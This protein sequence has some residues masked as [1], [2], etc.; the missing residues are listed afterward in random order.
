MRRRIREREARRRDRRM[1]LRRGDKETRW[2]KRDGETRR[3]DEMW[4]DKAGSKHAGKA[5]TRER[6]DDIGVEE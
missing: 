6:K 1:R 3:R 5:E 4:R 2:K